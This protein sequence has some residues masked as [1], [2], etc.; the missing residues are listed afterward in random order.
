MFHN[1]DLIKPVSLCR[2]A[3]FIVQDE[4]YTYF[5][6]NKRAV[7]INLFL[8]DQFFLLFDFNTIKYSGK[9]ETLIII[10]FL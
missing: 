9:I 8:N 7:L 5:L 3:Y 2:S 4:N 10:N 1:V 6:L